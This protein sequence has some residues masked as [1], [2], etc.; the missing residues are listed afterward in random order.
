MMLS[1]AAF[2]FEG[3]ELPYFFH[4]YNQAFANERRVEVAIALHL[5]SGA[6]NMIEVGAVLPHYI[7]D[8]PDSKHEVVD[9]YEE[10]PGVINADVL[11][12]EPQNAPYDLVLCI[13]TLDHLNNANE[14]LMAV[15]RMKSWLGHGGQLFVTV[16][17]G[18]PPEVG[19]GAWLD[20]LVQ[21][22]A[23]GMQMRRM[24]KLNPVQQLWA[25]VQPDLP[26]RAYHGVSY[27]ANTIYLL[28]YRRER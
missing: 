24:D 26:P 13:S 8:W 4:R 15:E 12:Y 3:E 18:Q 1:A 5:R 16:P 11:T 20:E 7:E 22:G 23:L 21:S 6:A 2:L 28:T 14:V 25:E 19:G 27:F 10:Y 9:L 17:Y